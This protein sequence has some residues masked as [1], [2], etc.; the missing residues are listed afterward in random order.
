MEMALYGVLFCVAC[1]GL[2]IG[3]DM[4]LAKRKLNG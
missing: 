1:A 4:Y 3:I 2:K